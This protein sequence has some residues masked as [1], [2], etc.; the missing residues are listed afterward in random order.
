MKKVKSIAGLLVLMTIAMLVGCTKE[1]VLN[2]G[3][4][5]VN[6]TLEGGTGKVTIQSPATVVVKDGQAMVTIVWSSKNY[7][8]MLV[9]D[10][11]YINEAEVG[12]YSTFTFPI[13]GLPCDMTVVGDT[14]AMSVPHEIEYQ[15][16]FENEESN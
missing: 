4:Y 11:K 8:Y 12:E 13:S 6:V 2:D 10:E 3:E 9:N 14:T 15:L 1:A 16:H 5:L 7:D